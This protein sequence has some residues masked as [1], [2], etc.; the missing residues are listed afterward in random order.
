VISAVP[1]VAIEATWGI[2][3]SAKPDAGADAGRPL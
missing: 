2:A 3:T 1:A